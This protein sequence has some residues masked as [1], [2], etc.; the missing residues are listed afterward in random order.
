V[1]NAPDSKNEEKAVE[2][3]ASKPAAKKAATS[4][5]KAKP[6]AKKPAAAKAKA[7]PAAKKPAA[8]KPAAKKPTAEAKAKAEKAPKAKAEKQ[9]IVVDVPRMKQMYR[10]NVIE[11]LTR[12]FGYTNPM[13]VPKIEKI[14]LN[15]GLGEALDSNSAVGAAVGDLQKITGQ[16]PTENK[17]RVSIANFKLREGSVVG[18]SVTLRGSRMWQFYDRFVNITLP[19]VRDF[20][21]ISR[22]AFDGRG[23]YSLGMRDQSTFPEIDYNEIDR[24]RGMQITVVTTARTDE[25]GRRLLELLGMPFARVDE[26]VGAI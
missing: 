6:A 23:N 3:K 8:K 5:A 18:S 15:I 2:A 25:E 9:A 17:A 13:Q 21:G 14:V 24:M 22:T 12:E 1:A 7:K 19:R 26:P 16:R 20:R 4:K 10:D 11:V